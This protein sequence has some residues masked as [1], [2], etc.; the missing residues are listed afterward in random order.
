M[1]L[2]FAAAAGNGVSINKAGFR[3]DMVLQPGSFA[4]LTVAAVLLYPVNLIKYPALR[5][6]D[7]SRISIRPLF[8]NNSAFHQK[9]SRVYPGCSLQHNGIAL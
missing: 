8:N 9:E 6:Q 7:F 2:L 5:L 1:R 4:Y 3:A